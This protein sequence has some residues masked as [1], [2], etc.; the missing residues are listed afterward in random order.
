MTNDLFPS[1][2]RSHLLTQNTMYLHR[3]DVQ[4][5]LLKVITNGFSVKRTNSVLKS[6]VLI[7]K[8]GGI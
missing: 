7:V 2:L 1:T 3:K 5:V 4:I 8:A 6:A